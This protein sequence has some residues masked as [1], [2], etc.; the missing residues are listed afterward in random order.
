[1]AGLL[2]SFALSVLTGFLLVWTFIPEREPSA[3][4]TAFRLSLGAGLGLAFSGCLAF[5]VMA[6]TGPRL[7]VMMTVEIVAV[8]ALA[9]PFVLSLL[10]PATGGE[11]PAAGKG[12]GPLNRE[13]KGTVPFSS[14]KL[15]AVLVC[16]VVALTLLTG[17][18]FVVQAV[19]WPHG[20][21][22]AKGTWNLRSKQLAEY[23][24]R[25]W[26][27][28][29]EDSRKSG[30]FAYLNYYP[31]LHSMV[32][33]RYWKWAGRETQV[34]PIL[35]A[36]VFLAATV[37]LLISALVFAGRPQNGLIAAI[38][39]LGMPN[40]IFRATSLY[41]DLPVG[42]LFL[43]AVALVAFHDR[44]GKD[45]LGALA[46]AGVA[47]GMALFM[48][49]EG[50]LFSIVMSITV[51]WAY[52]L[53]G[54]KK[55]RFRKA[56]AFLAGLAPLVALFVYFKACIAEGGEAP[57]PLLDALRRTYNFSNHGMIW[58]AF[59][60]ILVD[61]KQ[62]SVLPAVLPFY[63]LV[64]GKTPVEGDR[65]AARRALWI[66][67]W[68]MVGFYLHFQL[69]MWGLPGTLYSTFDRGMLQLW[70]MLL[71]GLFLLA[72]TPEEAGIP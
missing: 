25:D 58:K 68:M 40:V 22:D 7:R 53:R 56:A 9:V 67:C 45:G 16:G 28:A 24:E 43:A 1:M 27:R 47:S 50:F 3:R 65:R 21:S 36:G 42:F 66:V 15:T 44:L 8:L 72:R 51:L 41:A 35:H 48:K 33:M 18:R 70:P 54:E 10:R 59:F 4:G 12:D 5:L 62:W 71:L 39:Y 69:L 57:I 34:G 61:V 19:S 37:A 14:R 20:Q 23:D 52:G 64:V 2:I 55:L 31:P 29:F 6:T 26:R 38:F 17:A 11:K 32:T 60:E 63:L 30:L 46:L 13:R 49:Q